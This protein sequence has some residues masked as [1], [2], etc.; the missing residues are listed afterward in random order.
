M[1]SYEKNSIEFKNDVSEN[2]SYAEE[3]IRKYKERN[4]VK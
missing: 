3:Q 1:K 2:E 4:G